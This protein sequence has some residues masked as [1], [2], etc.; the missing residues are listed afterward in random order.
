MKLSDHFVGQLRAGDPDTDGLRDSQFARVEH[1]GSTWFYNL[2][3]GTTLEEFKLAAEVAW[4][5]D[6]DYAEICGSDGY[7]RVSFA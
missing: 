5:Q 3:T 4:D 6:A 1:D 7:A 2:P